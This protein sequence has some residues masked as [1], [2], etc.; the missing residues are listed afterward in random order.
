MIDFENGDVF[1][2]RKVKDEKVDNN[3]LA[4]LIP[5]EE[6]IGV[7]KSVRDYV[8]FTN[9]RFISVN[10]QGVTGKKR[11]Y[12]IMPYSKISVFSIETSG[13]LDMDSE[14]QLFFSGVG[15]VTFEFTG[16]SDIVEIGQMISRHML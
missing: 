6:I 14:L 10:I 3:I 2:L 11:D 4:L 12:T 5:K 8:V 7:Y 16:N 9:R 1:K 13:V 15:R